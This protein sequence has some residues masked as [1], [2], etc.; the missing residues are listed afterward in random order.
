[1]SAR[2]PNRRMSNSLTGLPQQVEQVALVLGLHPDLV[3]EVAV[4]VIRDS[5]TG[6]MPRSTLRNAMNGKSVFAN[7]VL[8]EL[9]QHVA[10][11]RPGD[12]EPDH[13]QRE[14]LEANRAATPRRQWSRNHRGWCTSAAC[15]PNRKNSSGPMRD[16][17]NSPDDPALR[18][19]HRA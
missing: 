19:Q 9:L 10:R 11:A 12:G 1:M 2:K 14:H 7:D 15:D 4:Y 16:T 8:R 5:H 13:R 3:A 18:V 6:A 17:E